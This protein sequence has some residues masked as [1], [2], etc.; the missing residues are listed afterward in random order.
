MPPHKP[1][2]RQGKGIY[3][4]PVNAANTDAQD[5]EQRVAEFSYQNDA[6]A[7]L[8][9]QAWTDTSAGG[10]YDVPTHHDD[11]ESLGFPLRDLSLQFGL[12]LLAPPNGGDWLVP[13]RSLQLSQS[14]I[15]VAHPIVSLFLLC[16]FE[17]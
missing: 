12:A 4:A 13:L 15:Y 6:L 3:R 11:T 16:L 5:Q 14:Q 9:V 8:I 7:E 1:S 2:G 17:P 10:F